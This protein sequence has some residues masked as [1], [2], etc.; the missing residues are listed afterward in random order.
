MFGYPKREAASV[1]LRTVTD[2]L[3]AHLGRFDRIVFAVF[4]EDDELAYRHAL[5]H[6]ARP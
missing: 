5:G 3:E 2:W 4:G 1:A 6:G